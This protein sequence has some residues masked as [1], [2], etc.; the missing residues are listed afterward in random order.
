MS[1]AAEIIRGLVESKASGVCNRC[2]VCLYCPGVNGR[3]TPDCFITRGREWL[4]IHD[5][6]DEVT[7]EEIRQ[8]L[9]ACKELLSD[10]AKLTEF[11]EAIR[12]A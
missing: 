12:R 4:E 11:I 10:P 7:L 8:R 5:H 3:H 2:Y 1:S 9:K 6:M